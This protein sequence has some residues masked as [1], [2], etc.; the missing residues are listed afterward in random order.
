MFMGAGRPEELR[1][2]AN[3]LRFQA[4][5]FEP[6]DSNRALA[7]RFQRL[8]ATL[9]DVSALMQE[10]I[11]RLWVNYLLAGAPCGETLQGLCEW[12]RTLPP[13]RPYDQ[14]S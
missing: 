12:L 14:V 4:T 3:A 6:E 8:Q 10:I 1:L 2:E 11:D 9:L 5:A 7:A 13:A